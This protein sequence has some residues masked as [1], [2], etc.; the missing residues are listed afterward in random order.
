MKKLHYA[1]V[2]TGIFFLVF[3]HSQLF[4]VYD[5]TVAGRADARAKRAPLNIPKN[6]TLF[7]QGFWHGF[8]PF[9]LLS[10][11]SFNDFYRE[12][13]G[14]TNGDKS[15]LKGF[16]AGLGSGLVTVTATTLGG[17]YLYKKFVEKN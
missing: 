10:P 12:T 15:Y 6:N 7:S 5:D 16:G 9:R 3:S 1:L 17:I 8:M 11:S 14:S 13:F 4:C 2:I